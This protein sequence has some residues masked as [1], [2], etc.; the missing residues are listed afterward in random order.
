MERVVVIVGPTATGKSDLAVKLAKE[1]NGIIIS[2]DSVQVYKELNI[3][4]AKVTKEEMN[5]VEHHLIDIV[6]YQDNY[7][8]YNF[9]KMARKIISEANK[10]NQLPIVVGGTGLYIK[11][12]IYDYDFKE[13]TIEKQEFLEFSNQE[14]WDKLNN[15]DPLAAEKIHLNN[16][17]RLVSNLNLIESL[18]QTKS[19]HLSKQEKKPIYDC[20]LIGLTLDRE[21]LYQR[22]NARVDK[23]FKSGLIEEINNLVTKESDFDYQ[24]LQAIGYKEFRDLFNQKCQLNDVLD[25]IKRNTRRFAKRQYTWFNNQMDITWFD[26]EDSDNKEKIN[27]LINTWKNK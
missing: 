17:Q 26:I 1:H 20:L 16:R 11:A 5:G 14:L 6:N 4:S 3:G 12:L 25:N 8:V 13:C 23:M 9:Q 22:I 21:K 18:G 2:G 27:Q 19:E 7:S 10:N 15:L 24:S